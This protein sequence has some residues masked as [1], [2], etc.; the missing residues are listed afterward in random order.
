MKRSLRSWVVA[1][2]VMSLIL[3]SAFVRRSQSEPWTPDQL[4]EPSVLAST[5][6]NPQAVQPK[7]LCVGPGA[8]IPHSIDVGPAKEKANLDK[9]KAELTKLPKDANIVIYC[10]CCPFDRCPNIRPAF[11]LLNEMK[12][13]HARLLNLTHNLKTDWIDKGYPATE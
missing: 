9:L 4:L 12:F 13:T 10:G 6:K 5:M 8:L 2:A 11:S 7:I 3:I 1:G